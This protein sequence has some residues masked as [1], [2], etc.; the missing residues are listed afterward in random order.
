MF[1]FPKGKRGFTLIELLVVIAIIAVLIGLLLPAVQKVREAAARMKCSSQLKQLNL[2]VHGY[3]SANSDKLPPAQQNVVNGATTIQCITLHGTILPHIEQEGLWKTGIANN[4]GAPGFWDQPVPGIGYMRQATIKVFAC[5]SDPTIPNGYS[6]VQGTG[7]AGSSYASNWT[8]FGGASTSSWGGQ[9]PTCTLA[10]IPDGS[11][12]TIAFAEKAAACYG[13]A[14]NLGNLWNYPDASNWAPFFA[15]SYG[16][17]MLPPQIQPLP[18]N[19]NCDS[20]R[21]STFH[22][23]AHQTAMMDGSVRGVTAAVS[24][25]TWWNAVRPDDGQVLGSD[26]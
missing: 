8:L 17:Y 21:P 3:A 6:A 5:P 2:A 25:T 15:F 11:S 13:T 9:N 22:S 4:G 19:G 10:N 14:G 12:N 18:W 24:P 16:N 23:S 1:L 7:W 20:S 26:W